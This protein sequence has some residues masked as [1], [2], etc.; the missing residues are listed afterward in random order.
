[1]SGS[2]T[3]SGP[4]AGVDSAS[5]AAC[6]CCGLATTTTHGRASGNYPNDRRVRACPFVPPCRLPAWARAGAG[7][8]TTDGADPS[9]GSTEPG[10]ASLTQLSLIHI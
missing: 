6:C 7:P 2:D 8:Q 9:G 10:T 4:G 1:M 5:Y 3:K